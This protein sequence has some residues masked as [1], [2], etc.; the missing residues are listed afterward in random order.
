MSS[1]SGQ[2]DQVN[3]HKSGG[4]GREIWQLAMSVESK[5]PPMV[6]FHA[7]KAMP[8]IC[9]R[10]LSFLRHMWNKVQDKT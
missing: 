6:T 3:D 9:R 1:R 2:T 4:R 10:S 7:V 8:G 5:A